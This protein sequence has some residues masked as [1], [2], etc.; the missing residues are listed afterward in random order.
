VF[1]LLLAGLE[2]QGL[3]E[4][5]GYSPQKGVYVLDSADVGRAG[6]VG[7]VERAVGAVTGDAEPSGYVLARMRAGLV[8]VTGEGGAPAGQIH[9]LSLREGFVEIL[10]EPNRPIISQPLFRPALGML[11]H[12]LTSFAT[13]FLNCAGMEIGTKRGLLYVGPPGKSTVDELIG[14][15]SGVSSSEAG[16][17][18]D[19]IF[20]RLF[21]LSSGNSYNVFR[22]SYFVSRMWY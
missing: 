11:V 6:E 22:I 4:L 12:F 2:G 8:G 15:N 14:L 19:W 21:P 20:F 7:H 1:G 18:G 5:D 16:Q 3:G 17:M 13:V 9:H 10:S